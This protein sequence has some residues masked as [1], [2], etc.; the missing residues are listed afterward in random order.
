LQPGTQ[1]DTQ[2]TIILPR[3]LLPRTEAVILLF[4]GNNRSATICVDRQQLSVQAQ[5]HREY[6]AVTRRDFERHVKCDPGQTRQSTT[7]NDCGE[8][9]HEDEEHQVA[10]RTLQAPP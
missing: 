3:L 5:V 9:E 2:F 7:T 10:R 6:V 8:T 1:C 4:A